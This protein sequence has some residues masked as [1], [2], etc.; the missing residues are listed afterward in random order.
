MTTHPRLES[1]ARKTALVYVRISRDDPERE[2]ISP[3]MQLDSCRSVPELNGLDI[4]TFSDIGLS[5]KDISGRPEY[6]RMMARLARGDVRYV[7]AYDQSRITRNVAD[8]QHF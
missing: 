7:V 4:E 3:Q 6:L 5:G 2:K 1:L 8:L